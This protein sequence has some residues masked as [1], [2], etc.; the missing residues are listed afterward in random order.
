MKKVIK[1]G[2]LDS[3]IK[4]NHVATRYMIKDGWKGDFP[5]FDDLTGHGTTCASIIQK[6]TPSSVIYNVKIFD[7]ERVTYPQLIIDGIRWCIENRM[8]II[9]LSLAIPETDYYYE[10]DRVCTEAV[11]KNIIIVAAADNLGRVCLPAYL[12]IV[13]GVGS[14]SFESDYDF[15]YRE[16]HPIQLYAKGDS[17]KVAD[18]K[19]TFKYTQGTS[20]A[21]SHITAIIAS[22]IL[23]TGLCNGLNF[24]F[25]EEQLRAKALPFQEEKILISNEDFDFQENTKKIYL[26]SELSERLAHFGKTVVLGSTVEIQLFRDYK[27]MLQFE[28][29]EVKS[30][31]NSLPNLPPWL[32]LKSVLGHGQ[33]ITEN[34][35]SHTACEKLFDSA[36][37]LLLKADTLVLGHIEG[38]DENFIPMLL[39]KAIES[40]K[41]VFLLHPLESL[42]KSSLRRYVHRQEAPW[43]SWPH[44]NEASLVEQL[45]SISDTHITNSQIL[46]LGIVH[47]SEQHLGKFNVE[48]MLRQQLL[49]RGH[50]IRQIGSSSY[51]EIFGCDYSYNSNY[52][53]SSFP[54]DLQVAYA[55]SMIESSNN[56]NNKTDLLI[57]SCDKAIAPR[58][59]VSKNFFCTYSLPDIAFLF[60][61]QPD[62]FIVVV[63]EMDDCEYISR[64]I[65]TLQNLFM[66]D[67]LFVIYNGLLG[68]SNLV[69]LSNDVFL[70]ENIRNRI[71]KLQKQ[72]DI[73]I[74]DSHSENSLNMM[75]SHI[76]H[77]FDL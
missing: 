74:F 66:T 26:R 8:D 61:I 70:S 69:R 77:H 47:L 29:I 52:F 14:A 65:K 19:G 5:T 44:I 28:L 22:L 16:G 76:S 58:S 17:Q 36:M 43:I 12:D 75:V 53:P 11:E 30:H 50:K 48:L 45:K 24:Q 37:E 15:M 25:V 32:S 63:N 35:T 27:D 49:K 41:N 20:L 72:L 40:G 42:D 67:V 9:N 10:F 33:A 13:F 59:F 71:S 56:I 64:N 31:G 3:G 6:M 73:P 4:I 38:Q 18:S 23:E 21:A 7:E 57:V 46:V 51:S 2:L 54:T 39:S 62:S 60:G 68:Y 34:I 55:K 1:I